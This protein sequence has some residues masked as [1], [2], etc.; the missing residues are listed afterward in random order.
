[1]QAWEG[2]EILQLHPGSR[3]QFQGTAV[4]QKELGALRFICD[5]ADFFLDGDSGLALYGCPLRGAGPLHLCLARAQLKPQV[6]WQP[7]IGSRRL[8]A[9]AGSER[10]YGHRKQ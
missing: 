2:P 8:L 3:C 5:H 4:A 9:S 10:E 7:L 1:M 6:G